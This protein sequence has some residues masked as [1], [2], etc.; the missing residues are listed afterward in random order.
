MVLLEAIE[1]RL[2]E[3][4]NPKVRLVLETGR[5][6]IDG[7]GKRLRPLVTMLSCG[8]CGGEP[9]K[10]LP[11][12]VGIEYIHAAS[13]LHDDVVDGAKKRRGRD[14]ANLIFG[15][16]VA[17]LTGD[18][19]Y[20]KALH[21]FSTY[22]NIEM[23]KLVS[24]AVMDMAEAQV[25][26]LSRVGELI[27]EEE[28]FQI[29]DGKT[30]VLFGACVAVGGLAGGCPDSERLYEVGLRMGRAFQLIDDLL[31]YAGDPEK[32]GKP[33]GNDLREGKTTYPLLSV[34]SSLDRERVERILGKVSPSDED[35]ESLRR[36]VLSL[37]GDVKTKER[38]I[39]ELNTAKEL[40][41]EFPESS[42]KEELL[43][44]MDFVAFREL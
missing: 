19:M 9:E 2:L 39:S 18:Y 25:L 16:E 35:V 24:Q 14:S 38:A 21:L 10:A 41:R 37:G 36:E 20:A 3:E 31:D 28:Y 4:L 5:Y 15:N 23:I 17:V 42:Y 32:T 33:V 6:L 22:G 13:L 11:L 44:L 8:M 43:K 40:L 30:A 29:I 7:G 1:K 12:G 26:E 27:G 34:L